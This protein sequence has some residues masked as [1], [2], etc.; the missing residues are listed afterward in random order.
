MLYLRG[1]REF[2]YIQRYSPM[3]VLRRFVWHE[4]GIAGFDE[5]KY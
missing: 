5:P 2:R 1:W 3:A 4:T